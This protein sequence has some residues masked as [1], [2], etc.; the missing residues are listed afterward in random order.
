MEQIINKTYRRK[1]AVNS[2]IFTVAEI[3]KTDD[4]DWVLFTNGAKCKLLT[5]T[6]E[7]E[8]T[9]NNINESNLQID[10]DVIDPDTFLSTPLSDENL[11]KQVETAFTNPNAIPQETERSRQSMPLNNDLNNRIEPPIQTNTQQTQQI[12]PQKVELPEYAVFKRAKKSEYLEVLIPFKIHLPKANKID[13]LN[14]MFETSFIEYLAKEFIEKNVVTNTKDIEQAIE[15]GIEQW[16]DIK[17]SNSKK[18]S[19][20]IIIKD[21]TIGDKQLIT[22]TETPITKPSIQNTI[23]EKVETNSVDAQLGR[24]IT[25]DGNIDPKKLFT[26][27]NENEYNIVKSAL[28]MLQN[29]NID[30][31]FTLRYEDMIESY[32][33]ENKPQE[34]DAD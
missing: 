24:N 34:T 2:D 15:Q 13:T 33:L 7:F 20:S 26:I 11:L 25:N 9:D 30:N 29:S 21:I 31:E 17:L 8:A 28:Q 12:V 1:N 16:I 6:T 3:T 10:N 22:P 5:L 32:E 19:K 23:P 4:I 27:S 18:K 14:D